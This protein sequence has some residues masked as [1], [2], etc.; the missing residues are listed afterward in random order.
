M[1]FQHYIPATFLAN[2]SSDTFEER[3]KRTVTVGDKRDGSIFTAPVSKIIRINNFYPEMVD[4]TFEYY[5]TRLNTAISQ[6]INRTITCELWADTLIHF[7]TG[8]L[9]RG[10]DF[11]ERFEDR[12]EIGKL[13]EVID[14]ENT[15]FARLLESQR[16]RSSIIGAKWT[17]LQVAE[18][19]KLITND[20]GYTPYQ[21]PI[22]KELGMAIPLNPNYVLLIAPRRRGKIAV[23]LGGVWVP[24]INY[25]T[26]SQELACTLNKSIDEIGQR[27]VIGNNNEDIGK[28]IS[29]QS[30]PGAVPEPYEL[31]FMAG[32]MAMA[33]EHMWEK[34]I[35]VIS[36]PPEN[37]GNYI[38]FDFNKS[39][40]EFIK[41]NR[42]MF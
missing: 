20:L 18:E 31:G 38:S 40:G 42:G 36:E 12:F 4:G 35:A 5:E 24:I 11:N 1:T 3:R 23:S 34:L 29:I 21:N 27:F 10:P 15:N 33:F 9:V 32:G 28:Y 37:D 14:P 17:V 19:I 16:L 13:E 30:T 41:A 8:L 6:L 2:F 22:L 39:Y 26:L 7:V 25:S